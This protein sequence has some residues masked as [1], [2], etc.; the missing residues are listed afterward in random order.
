[1]QTLLLALHALEAQTFCPAIWLVEFNLCAYSFGNVTSR[2]LN[3]HHPLTVHDVLPW[4]A[5][6]LRN[7]SCRLQIRPHCQCPAVWGN[8]CR[9]VCGCYH[10]QYCA[11]P[12]SASDHDVYIMCPGNGEWLVQNAGVGSQLRLCS[13]YTSSRSSPNTVARWLDLGRCPTTKC[14]PRTD[15]WCTA[16]LLTSGVFCFSSDWEYQTLGVASGSSTVNACMIHAGGCD[17]TAEEVRCQTCFD[18][19][20][21]QFNHNLLIRNDAS[22][23]C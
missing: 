7:L 20:T 11:Q 14:V 8:P 21:L 2:T 23:V 10:R 13:M 15:M 4:I 22:G 17:H 12:W 1:M 6:A 3:D 19:P 5:H 18:K 9:S 16:E